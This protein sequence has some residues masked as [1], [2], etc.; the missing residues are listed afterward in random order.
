MKRVIDNDMV[1]DSDFKLAKMV[2]E[3]GNDP[4]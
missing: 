1:V 4:L 3:T 2:Q